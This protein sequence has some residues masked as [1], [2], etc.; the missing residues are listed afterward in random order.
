MVPERYAKIVEWSDEDNCYVG[1]VPELCGPCC[2]SDDVTAVY[3]ELCEI[4][5]EWVEILANDPKLRATHDRFAR[6]ETRSKVDTLLM[7][8][9]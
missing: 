1:S 9:E 3:R 5:D 6:N 7:K 8:E 4:V 2:H